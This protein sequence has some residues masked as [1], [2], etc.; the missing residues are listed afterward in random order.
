MMCFEYLGTQ[1]N[2]FGFTAEVQY[3]PEDG[4]LAIS[5]NKTEKCESGMEGT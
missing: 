3:K 5:N 1:K 4:E 2:G